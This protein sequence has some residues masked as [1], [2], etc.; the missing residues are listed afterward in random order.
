M[1]ITKYNIFKFFIHA[2]L[3]FSSVAIELCDIYWHDMNLEY[4]EISELVGN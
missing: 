1:Q 4:L 2:F 3:L